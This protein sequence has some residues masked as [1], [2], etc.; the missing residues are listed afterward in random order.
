[1]LP[2]LAVCSVADASTFMG[3]APTVGAA[4]PGTSGPGIAG[5][6]SF[7]LGLGIS[8]A[9]DSATVGLPAAFGSSALS[10]C[11][12][13]ETLSTRCCAVLAAPS[14]LVESC[15]IKMSA[16]N[17]TAAIASRRRPRG[18]DRVLVRMP[19]GGGTDTELGFCAGVSSLLD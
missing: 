14:V 7:V 17:T 3:V 12:G 8:F 2:T 18:R 11:V 16:P 10:T 4:D 6:A 9:V 13:S 19:G 1:M 15:L 5:G